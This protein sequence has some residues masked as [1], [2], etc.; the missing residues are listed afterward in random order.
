MKIQ[1]T[2]MDIL[3][4]LA[5]V[6]QLA[7]DLYAHYAG[8]FISTELAHDIFSEMQMEEESHKDQVLLQK[9]IVKRMLASRD[10][11]EVDISG[12]NTVA[13]AIMG[14]ISNNSISLSQ[15]VDFA[16]WMETSGMESAYRLS[17]ARYNV[18]LESLA[19]KL[20]AED[21]VHIHKL[22]KLRD[23]ISQA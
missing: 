11:I 15:A 6:E 20:A 5:D 18:A 21:S 8:L 9:Q 4:K 14:Q 3:D 13:N 23:S 17:A 1:T 19:R 22:N 2:I 16:I 7:S 10:Y 12:V